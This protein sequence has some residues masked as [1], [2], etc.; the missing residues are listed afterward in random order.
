MDRLP[1]VAVCLLATGASVAQIRCVALGGPEGLM[2][3]APVVLTLLMPAAAW[4]LTIIIVVLASGDLFG[5]GSLAFTITLMTGPLVLGLCTLRLR[6]TTVLCMYMLNAGVVVASGALHGL[7]PITWCLV[8]AVTLTVALLIRGWMHAGERAIEQ[9]SAAEDE[10][11]RRAR[12]EERTAIAREL[13]DVVAHHMSVVAIQAEAA[14]YRAQGAPQELSETLLAVRENAV[15]ALAEMRRILGVIRADP[16]QANRPNH[17]L[18][19]QPTLARLDQLIESMCASG[20]AVHK[21][22]TGKVRELTPGVELSAYRI[23]QEALSNAMRHAPGSSVRVE[24]S[25]VA[26]GLGLRVV[27]SVATRPVEVSSGVGHGLL[28]MRERVF[29]LEGQLT[30]QPTDDGGFEVSAFLPIS[31]RNGRSGG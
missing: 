30:A 27:N 16:L 5:L 28:G 18:L 13:H 23:V 17:T 19:P 21:E 11:S 3:G 7:S 10:R 4:W 9:A 20:S 6:L 25:Y 29:M 24:L 31:S 15:L 8:N 26:T 2:A 14:R 22:V 1:Y 12:L